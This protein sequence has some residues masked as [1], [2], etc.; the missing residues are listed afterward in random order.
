[1]LNAIPPRGKRIIELGAGTGVFT[2]EMLA[3]GFL[4]KD[5]LVLELNQTLHQHLREQFPAIHAVCAD[6]RDLAEVAE[7][8]G[9]LAKGPADAVIS[10]LGMLSMSKATQKAILE[11]AFA[12][13]QPAG[14]FIQFTYGPTHPVAADVRK[15]LGLNSRRSGFTLWNVPPAAVYVLSRQK[16]QPG[17][18]KGNK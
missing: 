10:G 11:A 17:T 5:L 8:A 6:A 7:R 4:A 12:V 15:E 1:M 16:R 14:R 9:Y 3:Q 18:R 13:L 2:R